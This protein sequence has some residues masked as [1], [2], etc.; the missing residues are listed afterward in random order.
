LQADR[1]SA[2]VCHL[3]GGAT[4]R[5]ERILLIS[6][7]LVAVLSARPFAG[8]WNDASRLATAESLVDRGTLQ[9]DHSIF[10]IP[11]KSDGQRPLPYPAHR[12]DLLTN[13]TQDKLFIQEHFYSDK[14]P[15]PSIY[16]ATV[17]QGWTW[18]GGSTFAERPDWCCCVLTWA[19]SGLAFVL[20][21]RGILRMGQTVDLSDR[22]RLEL[23]LAFSVG[24]IA[25][26]YA[27]TV[28]AHIIQLAAA[29]WLFVEL[30]EVSK[31]SH[32]IRR[33]IGI[34]T[35]AGVA[36]AADSSA[37]PTLLCATLLAVLGTTRSIRQTAIVIAAIGP[38]LVTHH[39]INYWIGGSLAPAN[40]NPAYFHWEGSPFAAGAITGRWQHATPI[41]FLRYA[42]DL[43]FGKQGFLLHNLPVLIAAVWAWPILKQAK[44]ERWV[45]LAAIFWCA[46]T[47]F[48]A[49][50]SSTNRSGQCLSVRWFLPLLAAG[51]VYLAVL[52]RDRHDLIPEFRLAT[53]WGLPMAILSTIYGLW[54]PH[55]LPGYWLFVVGFLISWSVLKWRMARPVQFGS[56]RTLSGSAKIA[57]T[58]PV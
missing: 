29:I 15:L 21:V 44:R 58:P 20:A 24:T 30:L 50:V 25:V 11:P 1:F 10:I 18:L 43:L 35:L 41:H 17:Y 52:L 55:M 16:L 22:L 40:A 31:G 56:L 53:V 47:W 57:G 49:A 33:M 39:A 19:S 54:I 28:N 51:F 14:T 6:C 26:G 8:S 27:G 5:G 23:G 37:G 46:S 45:L 13:G 9:V 38:W 32:S 42:G 3:T 4:M 36:Y 48:L 7:A 34:G 2:I 12:N